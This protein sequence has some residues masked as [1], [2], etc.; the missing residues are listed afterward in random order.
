MLGRVHPSRT[1]L[2][3]P[4]SFLLTTIIF[5]AVDSL[6]A[7]TPFPPLA[8]MAP[9][10]IASV[11]CLKRCRTESSQPSVL[12]APHRTESQRYLAALTTLVPLIIAALVFSC[13]FGFMWETARAQRELREHGP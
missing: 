5:L 1:A 13:L 12:L 9:L 3:A 8:L 11:L 7:L 6:V 4:A 2:Y 10:P